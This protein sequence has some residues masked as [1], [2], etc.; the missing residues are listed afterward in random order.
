MSQ[1]VLQAIWLLVANKTA[2]KLPAVGSLCVECMRLRRKRPFL[3]SECTTVA[4]GEVWR[5]DIVREISRKVT[6]IQNGKAYTNSEAFSS[7]F[8]HELRPKHLLLECLGCF[9]RD[10]TAGLG[11]HRLRELNDEI[12]KLFR[13][14]RHWEKR[15][16]ELGGPDYTKRVGTAAADGLELPGSGGY[17]YFGE[18]KNLPGVREL[19]ETVKAKTKKRSRGEIH[20][21]LTIDYYGF[22]DEDDEDLKRAEAEAEGAM[23]ARAI[24]EWY[25]SPAAATASGTDADA[26]S[27][28]SRQDHV[29]EPSKRAKPAPTEAE[30]H[31]QLAAKRKQLLAKRYG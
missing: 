29:H 22:M 7:L 13:E 5:L 3:A 21:H 14:K 15:I 28:A 25:A 20:K 31:A 18:T 19:F 10:H 1:G 24:A 17:K 23:R 30:L 6:E 9:C 16:L 12:N 27:G 11:E 26:G 4:D 8:D 2:T